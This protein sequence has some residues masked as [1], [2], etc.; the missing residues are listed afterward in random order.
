MSDQTEID[1]AM[2]YWEK[3][4]QFHQMY[5]DLN[6]LV[7]FVQFL[8]KTLCDVK[9][10]PLELEAMEAYQNIWAGECDQNQI[11]KYN[12]FRVKDKLQNGLDL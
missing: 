9:I 5:I 6:K 11:L 2:D 1:Q 8:S 3:R 10:D 4:T 12:K 7:T